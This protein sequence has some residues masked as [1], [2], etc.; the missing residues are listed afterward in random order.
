MASSHGT[1]LEDL[2]SGISDFIS[3]ESAISATR[4]E[5]NRDLGTSD[6]VESWG[7]ERGWR[8]KSEVGSWSFLKP[9]K[10]YFRCITCN[11]KSY[12]KMGMPYIY[13]YF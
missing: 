2:N 1:E 12:R 9:D 10:F 4:F 6:S 3:S 11:K 7:W 8:R 13:E 5:I